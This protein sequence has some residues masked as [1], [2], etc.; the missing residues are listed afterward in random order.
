MK[1]LIPYPIL[2]A[3]LL[4]GCGSHY[5]DVRYERVERVYMDGPGGRSVTLLVRDASGR[6]ENV[7]LS[8]CPSGRAIFVDDVPS[9]EAMWAVEHRF[10]KGW[11]GDDCG[12]EVHI[13][14]I[15][16][17]EGGAWNRGKSGRGQTE[18]VE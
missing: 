15:A 10:V 3:F 9:G 13:H 16:N 7:S 5:T 1:K 12:F 14:A 2:L 18:V 11:S 6:L 8:A 4:I 17:V